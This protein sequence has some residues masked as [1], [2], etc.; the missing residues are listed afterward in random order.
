MSSRSET[1][2]QAHVLRH[3]TEVPVD[4]VA[5]CG[6]GSS[7]PTSPT[8]GS[9]STACPGLCVLCVEQASRV[10]RAVA[11]VVADRGG[12]GAEVQATLDLMGSPHAPGAFI[13]ADPN[14]TM[15]RWVI[16]A[17]V[18][19]TLRALNAVLRPEGLPPSCVAL[20]AEE[21]WKSGTLPNNNP[22][23][24]VS[25]LPRIPAR[26]RRATAGTGSTSSRSGHGRGCGAA[27]PPEPG[28][29]LL[30]STENV[31]LAVDRED[32]EGGAVC[33]ADTTADIVPAADNSRSFRFAL[34][35]LS[36]F[37][38]GSMSLAHTHALCSDRG[39]LPVCVVEAK[40]PST[41]DHGE[42]QA[43]LQML[44]MQEMHRQQQQQ[45]QLPHPKQ[46]AAHTEGV[47][48]ASSVRGTA[49]PPQ[50]DAESLEMGLGRLALEPRPQYG[51]STADGSRAC[52]RH[53][54]EWTLSACTGTRSSTQMFTL[55]VLQ[56]AC[57]AW[58][59]PS[60]PTA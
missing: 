32:I 34:Q 46:Y 50:R 10:A 54:G 48:D 53:G 51:S 16:D 37:G 25:V 36:C 41:F 11:Q 31:S 3:A 43:I 58:S 29:F 20:S 30:S 9:V 14:E 13:D 7:S 49:C 33:G 19:A 4:L 39:P 23:Y 28:R 59:A 60:S 47:H 26:K 35:L 5:M 8:R 27:V 12:V 45:Q 57:P 55:R 38:D 22:D 18:V 42:C 40:R 2:L 56:A 52:E 24:V 1:L 17:Y 6:L 44:N 15:A 21:A